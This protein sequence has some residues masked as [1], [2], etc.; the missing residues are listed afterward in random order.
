[1]QILNRPIPIA[2]K[3]VKNILLAPNLSVSIPNDK[4]TQVVAHSMIGPTSVTSCVSLKPITFSSILPP[5]L[6]ETSASN[7]LKS[8]NSS[9]VVNKTLEVS[10]NKFQASKVESSVKESDV[11]L[12]NVAS[13]TSFFNGSA[14]SNSEISSAL[15]SGESHLSELTINSSDLCFSA[16]LSSADSEDVS[17]ERGQC[18]CDIKTSTPTVFEHNK[19]KDAPCNNG[20]SLYTIT[21]LP[22]TNTGN[23][24]IVKSML[25]KTIKSKQIVNQ[26]SS[27]NIIAG[28]P[29][30]F[31]SHSV[32]SE[33][34]GVK[35]IQIQNCAPEQSSILD[36][37]EALEQTNAVEQIN[38][39][40]SCAQEQSTTLEQTNVQEQGDAL[41]TR[42]SEFIDLSYDFGSSFITS[43]SHQKLNNLKDNFCSFFYSQNKQNKKMLKSIK[44]IS[45]LHRNLPVMLR[46]IF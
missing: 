20:S 28:L 42:K 45:S 24:S 1:M 41:E 2:P 46:V 38:L 5:S 9:S 13:V 35:R 34:A 32:P 44:L 14:N 12:E 4:N 16:N 27:H 21:T 23:W 15:F 3:P 18:D 31:S 26:N 8:Q 43:K 7:S 37:S 25:L 6:N 39:D 19:S 36:K 40:Q 11:K 10:V 29:K 17:N 33:D 30:Y 22:N